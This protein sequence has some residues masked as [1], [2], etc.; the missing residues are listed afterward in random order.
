[1]Q[2]NRLFEIIYILTDKKTVTASYLAERFEVS[3]RT[4]YRD[5]ELLSQCGIPVY[6]VKGK[7]GG[8][9][10]LDNFVLDKSL[11]SQEEQA[12]IMTA[13]AAMAPVPNIKDSGIASKLSALFQRENDSWICVD[14][15]SWN[16]GEQNI[17]DTLRDSVINRNAVEIDYINSRGETSRRTAEPLKM[18][19]KGSAW[20]VI[21]YCRRAEAMRIFRLSR[22]KKITVLDETFERKD[23]DFEYTSENTHIDTVKLVL[24]ITPESEYR[25]YDEFS[26]FIKNGDGSFTVKGEYPENDWLYGY[27][28][29][30]GET[31]EVIEPAHIKEIIK[32][33]IKKLSEI[34]S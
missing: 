27:I 15:S 29:S 9:R 31:A 26:D 28:L 30:F 13:L 23:A 17:F 5:I 32:N 8:I 7:G 2:I 3:Q 6:T 25:V 12:Q 4:V 16:Y 11:I 18:W 19:F 34:Y 14:F 20:Y 33:K 10:I 24:K 21:A 1:M 22:I